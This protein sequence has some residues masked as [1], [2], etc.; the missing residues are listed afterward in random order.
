MTISI[1]SNYPTAID[2]ML[3]FQ[4]NSIDKMPIIQHYENLISQGKYDE[5]NDYISQQD[6]YGYFADYFNGMENRIYSL[7]K[8]LLTK[9]KTNPFTISDTEPTNVEEGTIWI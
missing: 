3:F 4:D 9:T 8:H 5:A 6:V 7:Q 1:E 2:E